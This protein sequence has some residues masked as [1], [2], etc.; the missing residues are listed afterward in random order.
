MSEGP[1]RAR[2]TLFV[3]CIVDQFAPEVGE[4]TVRLL[5]RLGV[6][7]DFPGGQTC[8]GQPAFNSGFWAEAK[9][10]ARRFLKIFRGNGHIVVPSGSCATMVRVFYEELLHDEPDLLG[11]VQAVAARVYELSEFI[12]DVLGISDLSPYVSTD[13]AAPGRKVTYHEACHLRRELGVTTQPRTLI[14]SLPGMVPVEMEQ[15]EVCCGFGGTFSIKYPDI[16]G[17]MLQDKIDRICKSGADTVVACDSSC[18]MHIAGG[19]SKQGIEVQAVHLAQLL[20]ERIQPPQ[21]ARHGA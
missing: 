18:L 4:S 11:D 3:T 14:N 9:P 6:E 15:S 10:L 17:A 21:Q 20:D 19:L 12:V 1:K 7:F 13:Q 16:S 5:R 2:S 8:C